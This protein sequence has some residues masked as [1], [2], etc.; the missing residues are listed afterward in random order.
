VEAGP[1]NPAMRLHSPGDSCCITMIVKWPAQ[2]AMWGPQPFRLLNTVSTVTA[3]HQITYTDTGNVN[4]IQRLWGSHG[5]SE[6]TILEFAWT[7]SGMDKF[8]SAIFWIKVR[9]NITKLIY[10]ALPPPPTQ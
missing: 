7:D 6:S 10:H 9:H 4:Y 2:A 1:A 3:Q 5:L 8:P